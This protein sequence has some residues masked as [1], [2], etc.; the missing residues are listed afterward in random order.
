MWQT[1]SSV[2]A[3]PPWGPVALAIAG[4]RTALALLATS[5]EEAD[6][7]VKDHL[8]T[9]EKSAGAYQE[10]SSGIDTE[11]DSILRMVDRLKD[12]TAAEGG[13]ADSK[14]EILALVDSLNEAIP[15]LNLAYDEQAETLNMTAEALERLAEAQY[16]D[17]KREAAWSA[18]T[19]CIGRMP[20]GRRCW[21]KRKRS[22]RKQQNAWPR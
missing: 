2:L 6:T 18:T 17:S 22:W 7:R 1:F 19:S 3:R 11:N 4:N 16:A 15:D 20:K 21:R 12:L 9:V 5:A 8:E 13:N 14:G 10:L